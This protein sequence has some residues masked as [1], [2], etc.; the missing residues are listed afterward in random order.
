M[1]IF[2]A[3]PVFGWNVTIFNLTSTSFTLQW[4]K[5]DTDNNHYA[6]FYIV[7]VRSIQGTIVAVEIVPGNVT[8]TIIKRLA[9]STKY[10]VSVF[11]VDGIGQP[12]KS[13]ESIIASK[14]GTVRRK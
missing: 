6:K 5:L 8:T 14:K 1:F 12:H 11:G 4:T 9:P 2:L 13:L 10:H 3:L 7:V